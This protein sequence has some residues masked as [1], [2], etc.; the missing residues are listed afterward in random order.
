MLPMPAP[1][2]C[3]DSPPPS[4]VTQLSDR[5]LDRFITTS[6]HINLTLSADL[7][8]FPLQYLGAK[9]FLLFKRGNLMNVIT[10]GQ[11]RI[12]PE[13]H[14]IKSNKNKLFNHPG[15]VKEIVN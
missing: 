15:S 14:H 7:L 5:E 2:G 3:W 12:N 11:P 13:K 8:G 9:T 6:V 10:I 4:P 1:G